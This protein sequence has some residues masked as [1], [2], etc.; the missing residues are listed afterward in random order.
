MY[1]ITRV[2]VTYQPSIGTGNDFGLTIQ[3]LK[4]KKIITLKKNVIATIVAV[5]ETGQVTG[6]TVYEVFGAFVTD[7]ILN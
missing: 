4:K 6:M 1:T 5:R 2:N 7:T 3:F